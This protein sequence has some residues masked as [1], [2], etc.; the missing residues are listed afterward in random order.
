M[1]KEEARLFLEAEKHVKNNVPYDFPVPG[2]QLC[3]ELF[4][5]NPRVEFLLDISRGHIKLTK[6]TL[7]YS[8]TYGFIMA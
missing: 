7:S 5:K 3:V 6:H 8:L 2:E 4:A 1:T